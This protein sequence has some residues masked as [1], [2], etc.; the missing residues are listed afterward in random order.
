MENCLAL[1]PL[2]VRIQTVLFAATRV[3]VTAAHDHALIRIT[4]MAFGLEAHPWGQSMLL[5]RSLLF[6][7]WEEGRSE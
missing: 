2:A 5:A 7:G 4:E 6:T 1:A 3:R